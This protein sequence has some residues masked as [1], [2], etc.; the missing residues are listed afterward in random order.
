MPG[1]IKWIALC[2][3][4]PNSFMSSAHMLLFHLDP[5]SDVPCEDILS[6]EIWD[7]FL[8]KK[9]DHDSYVNKMKT[10]RDLHNYFRVIFWF[11]DL[12]H[13]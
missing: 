5:P 3:E 7:Q 8:I 9:Q 11:V 2:D 10:W 12:F 13:L 4:A 1:G 6:K